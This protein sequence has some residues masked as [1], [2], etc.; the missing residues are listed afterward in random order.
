MKNPRRRFRLCCRSLALILAS[1]VN[2]PSNSSWSQE[3]A[4][5]TPAGYENQDGENY[6]NGVGPGNMQWFI[7]AEEFAALPETQHMILGYSTRMDAGQPV[8]PD[9]STV[10]QTWPIFTIR[11][12]TKASDELSTRFPDNTGLD[13]TTV[14]SGRV[15]SPTS[16]PPLRTKAHASLLR[17]SD[18]R[19]PFTTTRAKGICCLNSERRRQRL[20]PCGGWLCGG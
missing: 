5:V 6:A 17:W 16:Q 9:V 12:S 19:H 8:P 1:M 18:S 4:I 20:R 10:A 7:P 13:V 15:V 3:V 14:L 2:L 11:L